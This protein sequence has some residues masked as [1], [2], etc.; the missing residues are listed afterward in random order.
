LGLLRAGEFRLPQN[1][2]KRKYA[3]PQAKK[4]SG[5]LRLRNNGNE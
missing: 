2:A 3:T 1:Q 4:H 5:E